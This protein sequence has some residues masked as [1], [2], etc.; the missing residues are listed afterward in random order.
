M[1]KVLFSKDLIPIVMQG[2]NPLNRED[3]MVFTAATADDILKIHV[4]ETLNLI[5]TM[6]DL[7][8]TRGEAIFDIIWQ[9]HYLKEVHVIMICE[10]DVSRRAR[11]KRCGAHAILTMPVDPGPLQGQ[12]RQFLDIALRQAYRVI[13]KVSV[14][15]KL[16]AGTSCV[17]PRT[18]APPERSSGRN[19]TSL[20][21]TAFRVRTF[22]PTVQ[23]SRRGAKWCGC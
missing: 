11:C 13:L 6:L 17:T 10:D 14:D 15:G 4:E 18:S 2:D 5:V 7:P 19:W 22:F 16:M 23:R 21:E 9:S 20:L 3:I 8:G 12:V 1:Q